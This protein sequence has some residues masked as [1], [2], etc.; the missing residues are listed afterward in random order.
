MLSLFGIR[1]AWAP[2]FDGHEM[3]NLTTK[4]LSVVVLAFG[5][6]DVGLTSEQDELL[7]LPKPIYGL[8]IEDLHIELIRSESAFVSQ[9]VERQ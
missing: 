2:N 4:T 7:K 8:E 9:W 3:L 1:G 5:V 6:N